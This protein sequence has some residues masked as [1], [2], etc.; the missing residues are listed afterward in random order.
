MDGLTEALP[1]VPLMLNP[2][3]VH[4]VAFVEDHVS[5]EDCPTFIRSGLAENV[6]VGATGAGETVTVVHPPQLLPSS[7]SAIV[8]VLLDE[9]L[10]AHTRR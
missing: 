6:T 8:P 4:D 5:V 9:L 7:D 3:P 2:V 1:D 10:S